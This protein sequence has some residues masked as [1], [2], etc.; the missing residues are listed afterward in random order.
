MI[1]LIKLNQVP[2][3]VK[4]MFFMIKRIIL[5]ISLIVAL[6]GLYFIS[7]NIIQK[8]KKPGH[9]GIIES[10]TMDMTVQPPAAPMPVAIETLKRGH[11]ATSVTYSGTAVAYNDIPIYPRIEGWI[12][13]LTAYPGDRVNKGQLLAQLDSTELNARLQ[14]AR[15]SQIK[16]NQAIQTAKANLKYWQ[17][18]IERSRVLLKEEVI[19]QE[20]FEEELSQY[21]TAESV[22]AQSLSDINVAKASTSIQDILKSYTTITAPVD[23]VIIDRSVPQGVLVSPGM[24]IFKMAQLQPIRIQAN[25]AESDLSKIKIN[26]PVRVWNQK[27]KT[28]S[29]IESKVSAIFPIASM[30]T[31]TAIVEAILPNTDEQFIVGDYIVMEIQTEKQQDI[32]T[33]PNQ[34][35]LT[36]AQQTA[37]WVSKN[38]KA[39]LQ[40]V[41]TG[42]TDGERT[43]IV[44]GL[45]EGDQIVT[46]GQENLHQGMPVVAGKYG[47]EGLQ[48]LP[49]TTEANR[50]TEE[51][52]Y[53]LKK[54]VEHYVVEV[55]LS[56]K[57]PKMGDNELNVQFKSLHGAVSSRLTLEVSYLMLAMPSMINP[58]PEVKSLGSGQFTIKVVFTMPGLWQVNLIVK[59]RDKE[60][61]KTQ[62]EVNV[63]E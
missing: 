26:D 4:E 45:E 9:M 43:E 28:K 57:P 63:Q 5:S 56:T 41:T 10:Q 31:R 25:I 13:S 6:I 2:I 16:A 36:L 58:K 35:L 55:K 33:V 48:E 27:N 20:E 30:Q 7:Q 32:L 60:L 53:S 15:Y 52:N 62:F 12:V 18:K 3:F 34:A 47:A 61:V 22:Y 49:A 8:Y 14:E 1:Q 51:N 54:T 17:N 39:L 42:G 21:E 38:N 59:E 37:V 29:P 40:Y 23:G 50:L 24:Q 44:K 11:F 46:Q 19:T